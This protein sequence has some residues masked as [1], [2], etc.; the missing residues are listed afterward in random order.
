[1]IIIYNVRTVYVYEYVQYI[2]CSS[3]VI[4]HPKNTY[5]E[6]SISFPDLSEFTLG[7]CGLVSPFMCSKHM[8]MIYTVSRY[9]WHL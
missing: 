1:M 6:L 2:R 7:R 8:M 9:K 3:V 5:C 4:Q